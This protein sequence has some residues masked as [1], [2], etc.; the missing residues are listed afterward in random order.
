[1]HRLG[2]PFVD[3][4]SGGNVEHL[5]VSLDQVIAMT[6]ANTV[7]IPGHGELA[8]RA[9]LIAWRAMIATAVERV[10]ALKSAGRTLDQ[11]K[12][13]KPLAGLHNIPDTFVSEDAFVESIW[14]SLEAHG[15]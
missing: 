6:D 2:F 13:A 12:A 14:G 8:T 9:D 3:L 5:L 11:A 4:S 7:I 1:M 10:Q 15:R